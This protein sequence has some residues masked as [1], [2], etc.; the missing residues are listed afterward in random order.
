[1]DNTFDADQNPNEE[2]EWLLVNALRECLTRG[3]SLD[4][5]KLLCQQTGIPYDDVV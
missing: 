5:V 4:G 3:V 1:M 2:L